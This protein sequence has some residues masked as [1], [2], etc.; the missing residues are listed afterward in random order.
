MKKG[1]VSERV[2]EAAGREDDGA[3]LVA[4]QTRRGLVETC[5]CRE[6][7]VG[8]DEEMLAASQMFLDAGNSSGE[9]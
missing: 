9:D 3:R 1:K 8:G 6:T 2:L 4:L 5:A 7:M